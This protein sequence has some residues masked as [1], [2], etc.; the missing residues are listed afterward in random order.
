[1]GLKADLLHEHYELALRWEEARRLAGQPVRWQTNALLLY[2]LGKY[3]ESL[4]ALQH[5]EEE[6]FPA[7][8][9]RVLLTGATVATTPFHFLVTSTQTENQ[10][11]TT[12]A[13]NFPVLRAMYH[14]KLGQPE[15]AQMYLDVAE[16]QQKIV[17]AKSADQR[18]LYREAVELITGKPASK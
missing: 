14:H 10:L 3:A 4:A 16:A 7:K 12:K 1:M 8:I 9:S 2:R 6:S 17:D 5:E 15:L 18:P 11:P 13:N